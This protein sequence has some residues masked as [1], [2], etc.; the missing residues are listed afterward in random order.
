MMSFSGASLGANLLNNPVT[1][2]TDKD[3]N[4]GLDD[5]EFTVANITDS[6]SPDRTM[7]DTSATNTVYIFDPDVFTTDAATTIVADALLLI[8][9]SGPASGQYDSAIDQSSSLVEIQTSLGAANAISG[10]LSAD[11][12]FQV[13]TRFEHLEDSYAVSDLK[14][15]GIHTIDTQHMM[16]A[17]TSQMEQQINVYSFALSPEDHQPSGTCNFSRIDTAI[18][19]FGASPGPGNIYAVNYNVLRIMSG[20]G[21]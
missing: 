13:F 18:L 9:M 5:N 6:S 12:G 14:I 17:Y 20:M 1:L 15:T 21:G 19:E 7:T 2:N 4:T 11:K 8:V 16:H 10:G 3:L